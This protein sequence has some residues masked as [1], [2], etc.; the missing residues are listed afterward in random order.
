MLGACVHA[1]G[2][3]V[4]RM[5]MHAVSTRARTLEAYVHTDPHAHTGGTLVTCSCRVVFYAVVGQK[6]KKTYEIKMGKN[7]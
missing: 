4:R 7:I 3:H 1:R 5:H 6:N 2:T